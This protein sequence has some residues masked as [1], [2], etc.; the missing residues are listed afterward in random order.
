M[1]IHVA[2]RNI[3]FLS[4]LP[5]P[6]CAALVPSGVAPSTHA[7]PLLFPPFSIFLSGFVQSSYHVVSF[8]PL[9]PKL[10][11]TQVGLL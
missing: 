6:V 5:S 11:S 8:A 4:A 3:Y 9:F 7:T 2:P 1:S 10:I